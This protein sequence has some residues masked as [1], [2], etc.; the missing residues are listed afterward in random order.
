MDNQQLIKPLGETLKQSGLISL[1]QL[2]V[3]LYDRQVYTEMR[4]GEILSYRGWVEQNT[5]DFFAEQWSNYLEETEKY[6]LG[7]YLQ[8]AGLITNIQTEEI[9]QEQ[10]RSLIRFG[11]LA[12]IK[13]WINQKTLDFF[14]TNLF[15]LQATQSSIMSSL[16]TQAI[17]APSS[18]EGSSRESTSQT[19]SQELHHRPTKRNEIDYDDIPWVG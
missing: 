15:P 6:P 16:S 1:S 4:I 10:P 19:T 14:L 3:A 17:K 7:F 5:A 13:G 12:V 11:S 8:K 9:L 18:R 2:E